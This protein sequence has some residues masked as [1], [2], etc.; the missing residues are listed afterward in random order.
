MNAIVVSLYLVIV[1]VVAVIIN[2]LEC[3]LYEP[4]GIV[5]ARAIT[6]A[7]SLSRAQ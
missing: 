4:R 1:V 7:A 6:L 5:V 2:V 3:Y